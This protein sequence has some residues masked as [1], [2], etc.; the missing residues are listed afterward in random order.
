MTMVGSNCHSWNAGLHYNLCRSNVVL[1]GNW[2]NGNGNLLAHLASNL[3]SHWC[4]NLASH[5]VAFLHRGD[6]CCLNW[7]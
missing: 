2:C 7:H 5:L 4:A 1:N 6:N 3:L